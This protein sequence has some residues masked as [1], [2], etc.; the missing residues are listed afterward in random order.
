MFSI[1][2]QRQSDDPDEVDGFLGTIIAGELCETFYAGTAFWSREDYERSWFRA[3]DHLLS[4]DS[5]TSCLVTYIPSGLP[6]GIVT[7][8]PLYREGDIVHV[9][10]HLVFPPDMTPQIPV[11][12]PWELVRPRNTVNEGGRRISEWDVDIADVREF[13]AKRDPFE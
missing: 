11:D 10:Q 3:L 4:L 8:W 1:Q 6:E 2:Y 7:L 12:T 13:L 9:Q 5:S